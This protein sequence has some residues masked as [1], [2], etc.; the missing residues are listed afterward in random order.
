MRGGRGRT[1]TK[2]IEENK[3]T[4]EIKSEWRIEE[5]GEVSKDTSSLCWKKEMDQ[6]DELYVKKEKKKKRS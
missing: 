4:G 2:K 5:Q 3:R 1:R 6:R